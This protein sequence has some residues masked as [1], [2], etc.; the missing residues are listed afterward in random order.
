M[1]PDGHIYLYSE[2]LQGVAEAQA[3][4]AKEDVQRRWGDYMRPLFELGPDGV[5]GNRTD[6]DEVFHTD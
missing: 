5:V 1:K 3:A 6:M 2:M 4:M